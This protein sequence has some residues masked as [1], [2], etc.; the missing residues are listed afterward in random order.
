MGPQTKGV[1]N[2]TVLG[3]ILCFL[4]GAATVLITLRWRREPERRKPRPRPGPDEEQQRALRQKRREAENFLR[5]SG[6]EQNG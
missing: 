3:C 5:Y 4:S 6:S 1:S 2:M